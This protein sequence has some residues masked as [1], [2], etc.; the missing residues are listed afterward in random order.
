MLFNQ[1]LESIIFNR[2]ETHESDELIVLSG[3]LGPTP[4]EMLKELPFNSTVIYGMY[5]EKGIQQRLH[6]ALLRQ[7][8]DIDNVNIYYSNIAIHS[9]CYVWKNEQNI[10][11]ALIGSANFSTNGL[12]T[13]YREILTETKPSTYAPL[14]S[15]IDKVMENSVLCTDIIIP[16]EN[17][18]TPVSVQVPAQFCKISLLDNNGTVRPASGLNW[19]HGRGNVRIDDACLVIR[20]PHLRDYPRFFPPI[21]N[22]S[23]MLIEGARSQRKNDQV[24]I[25]WDDGIVMRGLLE[26]SQIENGISYPKNFSSSP[27]KNIIGEYIRTRL[28][29]PLGTPVTLTD[30]EQYG[31]TDIDV[32]LQGDGIYFFD[33]SV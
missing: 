12:C 32:S 26:G 30:L 1:N 31:R 22:Y 5:G 6:N 4:V 21:Q 25:I 19:G 7:Q 3:Y 18:G 29:V 11:H 23:P 8:R 2:H 27:S 28:G 10:C 33:F 24:E 13:P 17:I 9:K 15:Y 20:K 16:E 14:S